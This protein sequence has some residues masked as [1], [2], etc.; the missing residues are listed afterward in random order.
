MEARLR[1]DSVVLVRRVDPTDKDTIRAGFDRLGAESRY[2]RFLSPMPE[3]TEHMLR[4]LTE[5]DHHDHEAM[6]AID[7]DSGQGVGIARFIRT[8]R[9]D[10]AEVAVTVVDDWQGRGLGTRLLELLA[11]R[12][13]EEGISRFTALVLAT[14][15]DI[16]DLLGR[17]GSMHVV[18]HN[19][20][21]VELEAEL[22]PAGLPPAFKVLLR[23]SADVGSPIEASGTLVPAGHAATS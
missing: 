9:P 21:S 11:A 14:N 15:A 3:L 10:V 23:E 18:G 17:L 8:G 19:G 12:A 6:I 13:R 20:P 7:P 22:P 5:V 1:D 4:Y 2:R 16:I